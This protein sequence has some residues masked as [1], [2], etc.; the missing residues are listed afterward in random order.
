MLSP[1]VFL[2]SITVLLYAGLG[3]Y[4]LKKNPDDRSN[5]IFAILMLIFIIWSVGIYY[6]NLIASS[7]SPTEI[8]PAVKILSSG[9]ILALAAFV[10]LSFHDN[11]AATKSPLFLLIILLSL[12]NLYIIWTTDIMHM[13]VDIFTIISGNMQDYFLLSSV[14]GIAGICLLL[15]YYMKSKYKQ[16]HQAKLITAGAIVAIMVSAT[17]NIILPVFFNT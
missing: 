2:F 10:R 16:P 15:R 5:Q 11:R 3:F 8:F 4:V 6:I 12:Y 9:M 1:I 13:E 17:A 14:F 7:A